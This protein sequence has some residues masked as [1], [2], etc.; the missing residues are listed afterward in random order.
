MSAI[1][2]VRFVRDRIAK[3]V[4]VI[5]VDEGGTTSGHSYKGEIS[6]FLGLP[7]AGNRFSSSMLSLF[8]FFKLFFLIRKF[9]LFT[10]F[11]LESKLHLYFE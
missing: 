8:Y 6:R 10:I 7:S 9:R 1:S 11:N 5:T 4:Y 2:N 3:L